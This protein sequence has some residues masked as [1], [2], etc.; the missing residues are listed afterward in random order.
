MQLHPG[1]L[2]AG[3]PTNHP[4]KERKIIFQTKPPGNYVQHV[5]LQG[6]IG[7]EILTQLYRGYNK[8]L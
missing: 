4:F 6:C 3:S 7:D 1:R 5:N 2:S 8:H